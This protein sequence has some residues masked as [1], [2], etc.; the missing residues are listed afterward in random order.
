MK[1]LITG[2]TGF[3]G[4]H[5]FLKLKKGGHEVEGLSLEK[6]MIDGK[7]T[8][9]LNLQNKDKL[10]HFLKNKNFDVIVHLA[11]RIPY[12]IYGRDAEGSLIENFQTTLNLLEEFNKI[13]T[14]KFIYASSM[15]V[16]GPPEYLP[17][18]E[19][20]PLNPENF[21]SAGKILGEMLCERFR[22]KTNKNITVLRISAPYGPGQNKNYVIPLFIKRSLASQ[23][24]LIHGTGKR[25]QDFV[26]I[27][28]VIDAF[29][30]A[31]RHN[32]S[33]IY[34]IGSGESTSTFNL[35]KIILKN[36]KHTTSKIAL[37]GKKDLQENY[38]MR[39]DIDKAK[40]DLKYSPKIS[41]EKGVKK[42]INYFINQ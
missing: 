12:S 14:K 33:D 5:L 40:R 34:N 4:H 19:K 31:I 1:I 26:Y 24:I 8:V 10:R 37:S 39:V 18:D 22:A 3:I 30:T 42:Y 28:D 15:S 41:I 2:A 23:N 9:I 16:V 20:H 13:R 21:Y 38:K 25:E 27:T 35:A 29:I 7:K 17:V 6:V 11:A 32:C 36:I